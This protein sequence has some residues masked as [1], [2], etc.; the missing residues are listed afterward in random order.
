MEPFESMSPSLLFNG[1]MALYYATHESPDNLATMIYKMNHEN[2]ELFKK[3][4]A[5][6]L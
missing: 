4:F 6:I 2:R 1:P 5:A 3:L